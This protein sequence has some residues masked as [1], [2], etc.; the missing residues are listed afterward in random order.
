MR[1]AQLP[2]QTVGRQEFAGDPGARADGGDP[3]DR[4]RVPEAV[5][6]R[7]RP[8]QPVLGREPEDRGVAGRHRPQGGAL[9][10]QHTLGPVSGAG[11]VEHPGRFVEPQVVPGWFGR[12]RPGRL[13][14]QTRAPGGVRRHRPRAGEQNAH[15]AVRA[16]RAAQ[17]GEVSGGG[18][19]DRS[20]AVRQEVGEFGVGGPWVERHTD[21]PRP[22]GGED[23]LHHLHAVAQT[24]RDPVPAPDT[25]PG[26]IR[27]QPAGAPFQLGIGDRANVVGVGHP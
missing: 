25:H 2:Q 10:G 5:E 11:G 8:E 24:D 19:D 1:G 22:D 12:L 21:G 26:E 4:E 13:L 15:T 27:G 18:D 16:G 20:A 9:R 6:Q 3:Q 17:P 14:E 23:A 7:E